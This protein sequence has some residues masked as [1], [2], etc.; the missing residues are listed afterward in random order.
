MTETSARDHAVRALHLHDLLTISIL[1]KVL[2][3]HLMRNEGFGSMN[4]DTR[5][6]H[7]ELH[8]IRYH[9]A[10]IVEQLEP[11]PNDERF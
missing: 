2:E 9:L 6:F 10:A 7:H 4:D 11:D 8:T 3:E 5:Q 1:G